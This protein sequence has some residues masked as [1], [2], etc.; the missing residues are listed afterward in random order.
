MIEVLVVAGVGLVAA[1]LAYRLGCR[2]IDRAFPQ[3]APAIDL[4]AVKQEVKEELLGEH[5][6]LSDNVNRLHARLD[7]LQRQANSASLAVGMKVDE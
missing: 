6:L 2:W 1:V 3:A 4:E 5:D 7:K